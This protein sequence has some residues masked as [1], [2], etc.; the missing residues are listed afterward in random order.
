MAIFWGT[1]PATVQY[2]NFD[3]VSFI[4]VLQTAQ[5]QPDKKPANEVS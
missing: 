4:F 3:N 2:L 5:Y 1:R